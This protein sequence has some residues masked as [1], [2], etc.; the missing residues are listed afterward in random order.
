MNCGGCS[1]LTWLR[2]TT[3]SAL[4]LSETTDHLSPVPLT[5]FVAAGQAVVSPPCPFSPAVP[6]SFPCQANS[7]PFADQHRYL[8][9]V[10]DF[11]VT[12]E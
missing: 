7:P 4:N 11:L 8:L 12:P 1:F 2:D 10:D 6:A 5:S 9:V 3:A